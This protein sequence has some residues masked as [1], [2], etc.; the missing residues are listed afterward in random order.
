MLCPV[1]LPLY[2][3]PLRAALSEC[4]RLACTDNATTPGAW[5]AHGFTDAWASAAPLA[6][7]M[8]SLYA[9]Q[10]EHTRSANHSTAAPY[11]LHPHPAV[12][13]RR[14]CLTCGGWAALQL[15]QRYDFTRQAEH[16]REVWPLLSG[17]AAFFADMLSQPSPS[18]PSLSGSLS[19][20]R[21]GPS[22]S[23]ENS[24]LDGDG[25]P[26]FL[27]LNVRQRSGRG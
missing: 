3:L 13:R 22:H 25:T 5:M 14:R 10:L 6:P 23:P 20:L 21:W 4:L 17:S 9:G 2:A 1:W 15:W 16:L 24:F 8:W 11:C 18:R 12:A 19:T 27:A 7:P 26:R